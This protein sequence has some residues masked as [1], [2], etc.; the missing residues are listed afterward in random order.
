MQNR[1][2]KILALSMITAAIV[3]GGI[4]FSA[5]YRQNEAHRVDTLKNIS[6]A[7]FRE[8]IRVRQWISDHGGVYIKKDENNLTSP[9]LAKLLGKNPDIQTKDGTLYTLRNPAFIF[10]EIAEKNRESSDLRF[11]LIS[12]DPV[13]PVNTPTDGFETLA[14][15]E[16]KDNPKQEM[17]KEESIGGKKYF[18]YLAP[19][20][21]EKSCLKC[22]GSSGY[23]E[24]DVRGAISTTIP[25]TSPL[26]QSSFSIME[27]LIAAMVLIIAVFAGLYLLLAK[28]NRELLFAKF[29]AEKANEAKNQAV[30]HMSHEM[31]TP[32]N[33]I[34]GMVD[35]MRLSDCDVEKQ[36]DYV[37]RIEDAAELLLR[38]VRDS[39]DLAKINRGNLQ[40]SP[41]PFQVKEL[42]DHIL[43][44]ANAH[45]HDS[46]V[47]IRHEL[48]SDI[49]E[50]LLG[51]RERI[52]QI[53]T[54]IVGNAL[55]FTKKGFV[56]INITAEKFRSPVPSSS[57]SSTVTLKI[58]VE[59]S[60]CGISPELV[61]HIF[62]A[63]VTKG[64][65][66]SKNLDGC[67]L[68]LP[69]AQN[70]ARL[71]GGDIQCTTTVNEGSKFTIT[72]KLTTFDQST[73]PSSIKPT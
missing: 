29:E 69:I 67:G 45:P 43:T 66:M 54:N 22:H 21:T 9:I 8:H 13:N 7:L 59:D 47:E 15:M 25:A 35:V 26:A 39:L 3:S 27:S 40:L 62:E 49:P 11:R 44:A 24:G 52:Q 10:R 64:N 2:T 68:G 41:A 65:A 60:G 71:M 55:K 37:N 53:V 16:L 6:Q 20:V 30:A 32:L 50:I 19:F 38:L 4:L 46:N 72:L 58:V 73:P 17:W 63:Y 28:L 12:L 51:D 61:P 14:L 1:N 48:A 5:A 33:T 57:K 42:L 31:R 34:L 70:L 18:R 23:R 36:K 56:S